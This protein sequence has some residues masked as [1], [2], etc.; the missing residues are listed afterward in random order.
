[1]KIEIM[2][3]KRINL[4]TYHI[5]DNSKCV[6]LILDFI[7]PQNGIVPN[8]FIKLFLNFLIK[9]ISK[10]LVYVLFCNPLIS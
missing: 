5:H 9:A 4:K 2:F 3:Q 10:R 1:M 8:D 6:C 7:K